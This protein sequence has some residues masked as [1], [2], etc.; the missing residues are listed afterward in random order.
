LA[1]EGSCV[2]ALRVAWAGGVLVGVAVAGDGVEPLTELLALAWV[3]A[4]QAIITLI[5][6]MMDMII[7]TGMASM[8]SMVPGLTR[9]AIWSD[10]ACGPLIVGVFALCRFATEA[11]TAAENRR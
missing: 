8:P 3:S 4:F 6:T 11:G 7:P 2:G 9:V 5:P 1:E 10:S